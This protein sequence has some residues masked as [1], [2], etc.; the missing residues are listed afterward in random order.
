M[1]LLDLACAHAVNL[2]HAVPFKRMH[3]GRFIGGFAKGRMEKIHKNQQ[4]GAQLA[5]QVQNIE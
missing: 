2:A 1:P 3:G 5:L 4:L